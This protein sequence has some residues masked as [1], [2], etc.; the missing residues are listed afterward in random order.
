MAHE[1]AHRLRFGAQTGFWFQRRAAQRQ[2]AAAQRNR[3]IGVRPSILRFSLLDEFWRQ[4]LLKSQ[5]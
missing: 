3:G 2:P 4:E 5:P 1:H